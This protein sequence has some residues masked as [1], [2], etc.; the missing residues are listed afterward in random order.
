MLMSKYTN[1]TTREITTNYNK[2]FK[3]KRIMKKSYLMIAVASLVFGACANESTVQEL[4]ETVNEQA[5]SFNSITGNVTKAA[6]G[7]IDN[8]KTETGFIV[9]G[10]KTLNNWTSIA[11]T[12]FSGKNVYWD[13]A[14][15]NNAGDWV[16]QGLRF[17]DKN[18]TYKFF[19]VAPNNPTD[20][21]TYSINETLGNSF[22]YIT[23]TGAN[24]NKSTASD[25]YLIDRNGAIELGSNHTGAT[26]P[27]VAIDFHHV[28]AK[29]SFA[30][31][32]TRASGTI[33]VT[34]LKMTGWNNAAGTFVQASATTPDALNCAEWT[35]ATPAV[36]GDIDLVG[37]GTGNAS[38]VE[39]TC[40]STDT[41]TALA[42][43]YIMV[44]QQIVPTINNNGTP[45]D[46]SDDFPTA[47]LTFTVTYTYNDGLTPAYEETFTNQ[48][49]IVPTTQT[50]GTDS[51][52][53][54]TLDIKPNAINFDVDQ[55]CGFCVDANV[56]VEVK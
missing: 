33:T 46:A 16:Y 45:D 49:A 13:A 25:D 44:P 11:Q 18:G 42:D 27:D 9:Y 37:S 15:N 5:I 38:G 56:D 6:I 53:T 4:K 28:M 7:S 19:A 35:L 24:S 52:T 50:W 51:Y 34:A 39:L 41:A 3:E 43:W 26:N 17:W 31:K 14:A 1:K 54:Y 40:S 8:L 10:Y 48:V 20:G 55:I 29:V 23:I 47:G 21:A 30:L 32:S 12:V 2:H 22:G 36:A